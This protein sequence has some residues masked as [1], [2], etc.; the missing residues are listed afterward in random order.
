MKR[1]LFFLLAFVM[2][3]FYPLLVRMKRMGDKVQIG[4]KVVVIVRGEKGNKRVIT[5]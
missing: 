2:L 4:E 1:V 5:N 3:P